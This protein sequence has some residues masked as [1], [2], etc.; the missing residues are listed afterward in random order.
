LYIVIRISVVGFRGMRVLVGSFGN[1][2]CIED[3]RLKT[4]WIEIR[5]YTGS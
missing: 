5:R 1:E 3:K 2:V 4:A